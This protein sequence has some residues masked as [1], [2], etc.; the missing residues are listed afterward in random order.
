M[1]PYSLFLLCFFIVSAISA[2][3]V[4]DVNTENIEDAPIHVVVDKAPEFPGGYTAL[5]QF[6]G[7]NLQYPLEAENNG[8]QGRSIVQFVV[9]TDGSISQERIVRSSGS[10][11]L[12]AEAL[13]ITRA[14]PQWIPAQI[15]D[16]N[17]RS[18]YTL[19]IK[20]TLDT[21]IYVQ[22]N[23]PAQFPGG[24]EMLQ[25]Y[26]RTYLSKLMAGGNAIAQFVV[27]TNGTIS[28]ERIIR[29]SDYPPLD[30]QIL[31]MLKTM[32]TWEPAKM[33]GKNVRTWY[34]LPI[35][36][37]KE[38]YQDIIASFNQLQKH[39]PFQTIFGINNIEELAEK[40]SFNLSEGYGELLYKFMKNYASIQTGQSMDSIITAMMSSSYGF[41]LDE[42]AVF[43]V[44][45]KMPEYPGGVQ[46][47]MQ[48]LSD[49][50]KY[51]KDAQEKAIEG[52]V[53]C[54]FIVEKDGSIVE[55][56]IASSSGN[57]SLDKEAIRVVQSM[58]KWKPGLQKGEPVRVK[59]TVPINFHFG[60]NSKQSKQ[61]EALA[62]WIRTLA[63]NPAYNEINQ[64]IG[65][66]INYPAYALEDRIQG[67]STCQFTVKPDGSISDI[68]VK[69]SSGES[70]L[71]N[72]V[73]R[74]V[75]KLPKK[76]SY[77][78]R[79]ETDINYCLTVTFKIVD[80][81]YSRSEM[82]VRFGIYLSRTEEFEEA[83]KLLQNSESNYNI[84]F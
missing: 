34:T 59:F 79:G 38:D 77:K 48:F 43:M 44:V 14:V 41:S 5:A 75:R 20:F 69:S 64:Y 35:S 12:D 83:V 61:Q 76:E 62:S 10:E 6:I 54:Q 52:R 8:E 25:A 67:T 36:Y 46:A 82:Q 17:V 65:S 58:P 74:M 56:T 33:N 23:T 70:A 40:N 60:H 73:V 3:T 1:K 15:A 50:I 29:A 39:K 68:H 63:T 57:A 55:V 18:Y 27:N 4:S 53:I 47:M 37:E 51:P 81:D 72:E 13:R 9:N 16:A 71:D 31:Q 80:T 66:K 28:Y 49:N 7:E 78:L 19:P 22:A 11:R 30:N 2:Q 42:N 21:T 26:I 32:P 24:E 45:E 84:N